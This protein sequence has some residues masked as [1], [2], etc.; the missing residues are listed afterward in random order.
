MFGIRVAYFLLYTNKKYLQYEFML[1][2]CLV[3]LYNKKHNYIFA[4][5]KD[6]VR[7]I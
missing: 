2:I 4:N 5:L 7:R 3:L 1:E 6:G